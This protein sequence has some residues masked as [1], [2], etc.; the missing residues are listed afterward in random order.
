MK[1]Y[2]G[3]TLLFCLAIA[4]MACQEDPAP[5]GTVAE[6]VAGEWYV[7]FYADDGSGNLELLD[8]G[9]Y[10]AMTF[11]TAA[12]NDSIW[13]NQLDVL[14]F[15]VKAAFKKSDNT[16]DVVG[17][18][19]LEDDNEVTI[20]DGKVLIGKG[21]STSG[22]KTDSIHFVASF[23]DDGFVDEY[24]VAGHRRTGFLEDEH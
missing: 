20:A 22:V 5:G 6:K 8:A 17:G 19:N 15:Q 3:Y 16:F 21:R 11:N 23:S 4:N 18:T 2:I 13:V 14:G 9:Y 7:K 10:L 1:K 24:V 12:N